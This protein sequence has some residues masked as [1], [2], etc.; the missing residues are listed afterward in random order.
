MAAPR[1]GAKNNF[2]FGLQLTNRGPTELK[3]DVSGER[4]STGLPR[5]DAMLRGGY[6]RGSNVL[7][8]GA[9]GTAKTTLSGLF[10]AAACERG[11]R[12]LYVSFAEG[13]AQMPVGDA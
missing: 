9:P 11:E 2:K 8:S 10:A 7:I 1:R 6:H 4:V 5:L 13:A 3:Y 12:T